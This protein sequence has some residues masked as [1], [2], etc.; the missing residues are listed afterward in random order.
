MRKITYTEGQVLQL[1]AL[2]NGL[3][4]TGVQNAK[5]LAVISQVLESGKVEVKEGEE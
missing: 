1:K 2:L 5:Q 3:T 4:I